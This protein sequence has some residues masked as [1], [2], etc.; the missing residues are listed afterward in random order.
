MPKWVNDHLV[1]ETIRTWQ[2]LTND[3]FAPDT[4]ES[5]LVVVDQLFEVTGLAE[6]DDGED[7]K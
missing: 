2:P 3:Q 6:P 7:E 5:L 4:A 1:A